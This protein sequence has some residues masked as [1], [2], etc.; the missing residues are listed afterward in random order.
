M[1]VVAAARKQRPPR[2]T[3]PEPED[4]STR[5][6]ALVVDQSA[7][8][9]SQAHVLVSASIDCMQQLDML[10]CTRQ[11]EHGHVMHSALRDVRCITAPCP[12]YHHM[13]CMA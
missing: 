3:P 1:S 4:D 2:G 12:V 7:R 6:Q 13:T 9:P 10:S 5:R 8:V 11:P